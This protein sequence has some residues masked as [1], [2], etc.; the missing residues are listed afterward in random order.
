MLLAK[1]RYHGQLYRALNPVYARDPLSGA[2]AARYGGRFNPVG[3]PALYTA[4]T[5]ATALREANQVGDLQP[6]VLVAYRADIAPLFDTRDTAA[7]SA[8]GADAAMLAHAGWRA[9]MLA[10][11]AVPTQDMARALIADGYAGLLVRSFARGMTEADLNVVL[12]RWT[13]DASTLR[14]IDDD[15]RLTRMSL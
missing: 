10:G 7:L 5:P 15:G 13:S 8:Y 6:T 1:G 4:L 11:D 3:L 14:V 2:G 9:A 12:W